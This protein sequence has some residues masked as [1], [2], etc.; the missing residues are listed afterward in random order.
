MIILRRIG[1]LFCSLKTG[2]WSI[3]MSAC[4]LSNEQNK[5]PNLLSISTW[6]VL[7]KQNVQAKKVYFSHLA[8]SS[9]E[10]G[11]GTV[12]LSHHFD[13]YQPAIS[14]SFSAF[15]CVVW[16]LLLGV[17]SFSLASVFLVWFSLFYRRFTNWFGAVRIPCVLLSA[18]LVSLFYYF[19]IL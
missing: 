6:F 15:F 8:V 7:G 17:R 3:N 10:F 12:K 1:F 14:W 13:R 9:T 2:H 19:A 18:W 16:G 11:E 5:G 4:T